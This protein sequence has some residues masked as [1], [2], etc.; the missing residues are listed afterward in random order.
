[1]T[2]GRI[3]RLVIAALV[4]V[5][6]IVGLGA[7]M[8]VQAASGDVTYLLAWDTT[9]VEWGSDGW[10]TTT[11]LGYEVSVTEATLVT[12]SATMVACE[13][14][15]GGWLAWLTGVFAPA[16]AG[17]SHPSE[18]DTA[19][20]GG[21]VTEDLSAPATLT[22][23]TSTVDE[24]AYCEG[25]TAWGSSDPESATLTVS[26]TWTAPDGTAG[27]LAIDTT[28]DWGAQA[29]LTESGDTVHLEVGEPAEITIT[30]TLATIFDGVDFARG[31]STE[32]AMAVLGSIADGTV[33]EVTSGTAHA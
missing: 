5:T 26:G 6:S 21:P 8:P 24:P 12:Y 7:L 22:L 9:G 19:L 32:Q 30:R 29:E 33:F 16:V 31:T 25:H 18:E 20:I 13:H 28:I 23:G 3:R 2:T 27:P 1:M 11:D 14:D 15:H 10:S 17:A 4:A